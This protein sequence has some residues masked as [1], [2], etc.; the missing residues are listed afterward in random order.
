MIDVSQLSKRE[1]QVVALLSMGHSASQVAE[2]LCI[3]PKTV[4]T[5]RARIKIRFGIT[6]RLQWMAF[7]KDYPP[8]TDTPDALT[9]LRRAAARLKAANEELHAAE[10][11]SRLAN[12]HYDALEKSQAALRTYH[13]EVKP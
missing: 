7:L 8:P 4:E 2:R 6:D 13:R 5:H 1:R 10:V 3:S 12:E 9:R 11:E